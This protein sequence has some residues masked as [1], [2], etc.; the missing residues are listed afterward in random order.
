[1]LTT[2]LDASQRAAVN[3]QAT[4]TTSGSIGKNME[5]S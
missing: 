2:N 5:C 1:M 4:V 3:A